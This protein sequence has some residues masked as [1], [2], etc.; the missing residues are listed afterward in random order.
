MVPV[1]PL[2][3]R[4]RMPTAI[5]S[6]GITV[7]V[8][9]LG[10]DG[11]PLLLAHGTGF[12]GLVWPPV[13]RSLRARFHCWA[14]DLRAHGDSGVPEDFDWRGFGLDVLAVIDTFGLT[15]AYGAAHSMGGAALLLA[16]QEA[17]GTF[18]ALYLYEPAV[19]GPSEDRARPSATAVSAA[20]R[21]EVFPSRAAAL[22]NYT[23]KPPMCSFAPE[24][25]AGYV[26]H[27][28]E[29]LPDGSVRL[30][31][32]PAHEAAVFEGFPP[33]AAYAGLSKV[34]CPVILGYGAE[35]DDTR[36]TDRAADLSRLADSR[37]VQLT[38]LDHFGP[39][40]HPR[41]VADSIAA[42][43]AVPYGQTPGQPG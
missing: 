7:A 6:D 29:D 19:A 9:D 34:L 43:F 10:G 15:G 42:A 26:T 4:R 33:L 1:G 36:R 5:T 41:R 22:A 12:H 38:A 37:V 3:Y 31:C 28:F 17:P 16:E 27:G 35:S 39:L 25:L 23:A 13:A 32:R 14:L 40:V 11:P 2:T 24:V 20:R 8:H 21:R 30:K 18:E